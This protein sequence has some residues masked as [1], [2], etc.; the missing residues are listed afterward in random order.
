MKK[1]FLLF[2]IT[3]IIIVS[4]ILIVVV[5]Y[6][7]IRHIIPDSI[8]AKLPSS[9]L[10]FHEE[11]MIPLQTKLKSLRNPNY[12]YNVL[13]LP[14]THF[15]SMNLKKYLIKNNHNSEDAIFTEKKTP[16]FLDLF[17]KNIIVST[18]GAEIFFFDTDN[19]SKNNESLI[20]SKINSNLVSLNPKFTVLDALVHDEDLFISG[21][22]FSKKGGNNCKKFRIFK[23]KINFKKIN[24][25]KIYDNDQCAFAKFMQAGRMQKYNLDNSE[26]ILFSMGENEIDAPN[27]FPQDDDSHYGKIIFLNLN[28]LETQIFSKGHR[29]PQGLLVVDNKIIST[30]HGPQGGDEINNIKRNKNYGWPISSYGIYYNTNKKNYLKSHKKY[31]FEEP[32]FTYI[33]AIGISEIIKLPSKF[34]GE[35]DLNNIFFISSLNG[36]SLFLTKLDENFEK[37]IFSEKIFINHRI[38][39]LKYIDDLNSVILALEDPSRI[40]IIK[41]N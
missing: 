6:K 21:F 23:G 32:I 29:N 15:S 35:I 2:A 37:L 12:F 34:L 25:K 41:N 11:I 19:L 31:G 27:E 3:S 10:V 28:N 4:M 20:L 14:E 36:K 38:R 5:N 1:K 18:S 33:P 22:Q 24:F 9:V 13:F 17:D 8:K 7:T 30:E 16:Y 40:A 26:G 39:D